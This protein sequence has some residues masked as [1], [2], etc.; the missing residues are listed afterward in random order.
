MAVQIRLDDNADDN[1][2]FKKVLLPRKE[3]TGVIAGF[4]VVP[5]KKTQKNTDGTSTIVDAKKVVMEVAVP[6][7]IVSAW[8]NPKV[9]KARGTYRPSELYKLLS[10]AKLIEDIAQYIE[11]LKSEEQLANYLK[12]KLEGKTISFIPLNITS[13]SGEEYSL[14]QEVLSVQ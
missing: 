7:G 14:I 13:K 10:T 8:Y 4:K 6:E 1:T 9:T 12:S 3:T 5:V 11:T 2:K